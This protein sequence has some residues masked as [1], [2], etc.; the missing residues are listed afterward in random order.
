MQQYRF[1]LGGPSG[2]RPGILAR[3]AWSVVAV[4]TLVVAAFLG[5]VVFLAA[6]GFLF[7]GAIVLMGRI[8]WAQRQ[9]RK[10]KPPGDAGEADRM[11]VIEGE[12]R[13]VD[14]ARQHPSGERDSG[15]ER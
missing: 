7:I 4:F 2:G 9:V 1:Q 13:V 14:A 3:L 15:G 12:Y 10:A 11:Q 8:W 6:L 5:A